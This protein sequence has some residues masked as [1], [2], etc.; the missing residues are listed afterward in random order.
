M[1]LVHFARTIAASEHS[2]HTLAML[3]HDIVHLT[4][5]LATSNAFGKSDTKI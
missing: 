1:D 4:V 3:I 2:T 5:H